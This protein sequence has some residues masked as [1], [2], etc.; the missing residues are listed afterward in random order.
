VINGHRVFKA[1]SPGPNFSW[2]EL[3]QKSGLSAAEAAREQVELFNVRDDPG[4]SRNLAGKHPDV[5]RD[6]MGRYEIYAREAA[7]LLDGTLG[8]DTVPAVWGEFPTKS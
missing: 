8:D 1:E 2:A 3:G 7:P 4:E 6:L 5:L